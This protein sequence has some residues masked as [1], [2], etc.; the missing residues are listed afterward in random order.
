MKKVAAKKFFA[1]GAVA[2][3]SGSAFA[4]ASTSSVQLYGIVDVAYRHTN[5]E[6]PAG[7]SSQS[8]NQLVGGGMS[9]SRWGINVTE[10][11]GGGT[12]ALV[13]MENRFGADTGAPN[14]GATGPYFQQSWVGL[15]GGY[16]RLTMGRQYNILFDLVTSTY[17]SYPYSPYMDVYKPEIGFA[18]GSR[19]DNMIKYMAEVGPVRGALQYSFDE[20]SP[21][22]G[23]TVGGYLRYAANGLAAGL[24]YQNYEFASGKKLEA[25]TLGGSYRMDKWY[26]NAG[27]G[28]NKVD[29]LTSPVDLAV[30]GAMWQG[31]T[32]GGFG[33][34]A[35][36][37]ANKR[38]IYK[39]GVGYQL[40]PQMN[41]G[42]HYFHAKQS[43]ANANADST[44]NFV[45]MALDYAFSKRTDAYIEVDNTRLKGNVSLTSSAAGV[46]VNGAKSRTG[47]T[48]G[49]RHRF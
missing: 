20:K 10:D 33:G 32:N 4:Q 27:Y 35:F 45:T 28:E 8:L 41:L 26:F 38:T 5:N 42:A 14:S 12:K 43:G 30:L 34:P 19:A 24:G 44:A 1:L 7:N 18:L 17:A 21:T 37:T 15:Q 47:F 25:W 2:L 36:L 49:L 23:K 9:Q 22:G 13:N 39:L 48:V 11:L 46:G 6:G 40:T 31:T 3:V 29:Q 16:G